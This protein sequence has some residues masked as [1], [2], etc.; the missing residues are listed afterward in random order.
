MDKD[1]KHSKKEKMPPVESDMDAFLDAGLPGS[2]I[3]ST[4]PPLP[5]EE[6]IS[7]PVGSQAGNTPSIPEQSTSPQGK[8]AK[9][10]KGKTSLKPKKKKEAQGFL[11]PKPYR[12]M[13]FWRESLLFRSTF[14]ALLLLIVTGFTF[15]ARYYIVDLWRIA[16]T[17]E[18]QTALEE[19]DWIKSSLETIAPI[20]N[21]FREVETLIQLQPIP[22]SPVLAAV[23]QSIP[24]GISI[25]S[26][27]WDSSLEDTSN[28]LVIL[29]QKSP[30]RA[31]ELPTVRK[32]RIQM[33]VYAT[34]QWKQDNPNTSPIAWMEGL[35][36]ELENYGLSIIR[37][38]IGNEEPFIVPPDLR[39]IMPQEEAGTV[40]RVTL[41]IRN[42]APQAPPPATNQAE[43]PQLQ[44]P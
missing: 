31:G 15:L 28:N 8:D 39:E 35:E 37:R 17:D 43:S 25:N 5:T 34:P 11:L 19:A 29:G 16:A 12:Q 18:Y 9:A 10:K 13:M 2:K 24:D 30:P 22:F 38:N 20:R 23:E 27:N 32:A 40:I 3:S 36:Q 41:E 7:M 26:M 1:P 4:P 6:E 21:K 42:D 44:L 33:E 14:L